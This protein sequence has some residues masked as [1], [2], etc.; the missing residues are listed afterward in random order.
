MA[1]G[2]LLEVV[3]SSREYS[4]G[5]AVWSRLLSRFS[6]RSRSFNK[7]HLTPTCTGGAVK[8]H[9]LGAK[10]KNRRF[11]CFSTVLSHVCTFL[12]SRT[13][14]RIFSFFVLLVSFTSRLQTGVLT[15]LLQTRHGLCKLGRTR[16]LALLLIWLP[17]VSPTSTLPTPTT[18]PTAACP[19]FAIVGDRGQASVFCG[20]VV[21]HLD[22]HSSMPHTC[23]PPLCGRAVD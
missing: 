16:C 2:E 10:A 11:F 8:P 12:H 7:S 1:C 9:M 5:N 21:C 19:G 6:A 13:S 20:R 14:K 17:S 18:T 22:C 15:M 3:A 23:A 4:I